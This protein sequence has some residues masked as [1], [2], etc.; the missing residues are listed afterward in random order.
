MNAFN[1]NV[2]AE[3][4]ANNGKVGGPFEGRDNMV[5]ITTTGAKSGRQITNPLVFLPDGDRIVLI[6]SNG[7]AD[8]HPAWYHNLRAN[9]E[10]TVEL[11]TETYTGKAEFI[12][13][14]ERGE[15]YDRMVEI[16]PQFDDYRT[17]T[18][19][20]IPVVAVYRQSA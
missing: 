14:P 16:M 20:R 11:G 17:G 15:L 9:P 10:L 19:R 8:K 4:R 2:I 12:E 18:T 13:D 5:V 3:F 6:A 1:E 7:G